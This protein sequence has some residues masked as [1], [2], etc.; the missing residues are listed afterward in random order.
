MVAVKSFGMLLVATLIGPAIG[1]G[2]FMA[3]HSL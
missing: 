2:L 3:M 1:V